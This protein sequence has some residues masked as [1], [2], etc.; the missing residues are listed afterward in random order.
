MT[1]KI[2]IIP[3]GEVLAREAT[4]TDVGYITVLP[5]DPEDEAICTQGGFKKL[6]VECIQSVLILNEDDVVIF[7]RE[8]LADPGCVPKADGG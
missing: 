2:G 1:I 5:L 8:M 3:P 4:P 7:V 6:R